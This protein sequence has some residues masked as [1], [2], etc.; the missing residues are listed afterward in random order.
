MEEQRAVQ[1][2]IVEATEEGGK[3]QIQCLTQEGTWLPLYEMELDN[4]RIRKLYRLPLLFKLVYAGHLS[5][6]NVQLPGE[7]SVAM[8]H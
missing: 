8:P 6:S 7:T 2:Q 4:E 5:Q 3:L 1:A